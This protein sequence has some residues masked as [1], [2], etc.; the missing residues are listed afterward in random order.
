MDYTILEKLYQNEPIL[1]YLRYNPKWY[2]PLN[3]NPESYKD[4]E[5]EAKTNLKLTTADKIENLKNQINFINSMI[6]YI[7]NS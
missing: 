1:R 3:Q 7:N 4:F 6:K 5:K 2:I